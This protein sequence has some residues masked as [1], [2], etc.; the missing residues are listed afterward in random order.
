MM[1]EQCMKCGLDNDT[2]AKIDYKKPI[3]KQAIVIQ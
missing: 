1:V 3:G 2:K